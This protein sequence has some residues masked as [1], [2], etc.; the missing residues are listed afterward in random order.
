MYVTSKIVTDCNAYEIGQRLYMCV[1]YKIDVCHLQ[2]RPP[3][4]MYFSYE[5]GHWL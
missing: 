1:T 3:I 5:I 2:N 4:V